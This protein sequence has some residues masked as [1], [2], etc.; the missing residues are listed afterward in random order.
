[1]P[2]DYKKKLGSR[3]YKSY[4][5]EML[6]KA[7]EDV[8]EGRRTIRAASE[9]H[10]IPYGTLYNKYKGKFMKRPGAQ[11]IF[12]ESEEIAILKAAAKCGDWGYPLTSLDLRFLA[13][14]YL[15][16]QGRT[17]KKF[18]NNL[19]GVDWA[20]SLLKRHKES[21]SQRVASNIKK[22]RANVSR[23][24][25]NT[26]FDNL[27]KIVKDIPSSHIFNYDETNMS[28][29]PGQKLGIY[30]RGVKYPER[31]INHSKSAT[32]VMV[33]GS[34]DGVLLP[35][36]I[37]YRS[38]HLYNTWK[39]G[40]PCGP[41]CC[42]KSCCSQGSRYNRTVS[43]WI[44][45]VT[46]RDW[47]R[48][49]FLPHAKKLPGRKVLIGD[50][51]SCHL[52][53]D[54][55]NLCQENNIDFICLVPHSTHL[56]QPL[57]VAFFRPMKSSWRTTLTNWKIQNSKLSSVP[58]DAFPHLLK[59]ALEKMD[60]V[61]PKPNAPLSN[62]KSAIKR[63]MISAFEATGICPLNRERVLR[64]LPNESCSALNADEAIES[65]L[66]DYL[67]EQRFGTSSSVSRRRTRLNLAPG[68]S[69][70]S[71]QFQIEAEDDSE[72]GLESR[73]L[74]STSSKKIVEV[75]SEDDPETADFETECTIG[76]FILAKF[77][78][79]R[80]KKTYKYV[81]RIIGLSPLVVEGFKST[82]VGNKRKFRLVRDDISE[83]DNTDIIAFLPNPLRVQTEG[84]ECVEFNYDINIF[85]M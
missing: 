81:C 47:F 16:K 17:V 64:R 12:S 67:R 28:D 6:N 14:A 5:E 82:V 51:L 59:K 30:K 56:C 15:D 52:D 32:T 61:P 26:Y 54:V 31:V 37:I 25:L 3:A 23:E 43:G 78:T 70:S 60:S 19:P 55:I 66:T 48:T 18:S 53:T 50:N 85:E 20:Y 2:R 13:K 9:A 38:L 58:K 72:D 49:C 63:N 29:D 80:G 22:A 7:L 65:V 8:V 42:D 34:A 40:G 84:P 24:S 77:F 46:F 10:K 68:E 33:C 44:D 39:E 1:M 76:R 62:I 36:Y 79:A 21:F 71:T 4:N 75:E 11:T 69:A 45:T 41:P 73:S 74:A 83:I 35:P 27:E 57:D